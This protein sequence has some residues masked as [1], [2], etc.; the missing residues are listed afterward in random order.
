[1]ENQ[2][3]EFL[4]QQKQ[5]LVSAINE[6]NSASQQDSLRDYFAGLAMQGVIASG[7]RDLFEVAKYAYEVADAM[8]ETRGK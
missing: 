7:W 8:L 1:M 5:M 6:T 3:E 4:A 2:Y